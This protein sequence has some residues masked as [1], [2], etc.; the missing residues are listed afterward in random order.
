M[1]TISHWRYCNYPWSAWLAAVTSYLLVSVS[2]GVR[3]VT[4]IVS[5]YICNIQ[6]NGAIVPPS[7]SS[8][9]QVSATSN[10]TEDDSTHIQ[11]YL[12]I[13]WVCVSASHYTHAYSSW[14]LSY[15][16]YSA[17]NRTHFAA[18]HILVTTSRQ[19]H[20][21][22]CCILAVHIE[23][24]LGVHIRAIR[25]RLGKCG[26]AAAWRPTQARSCTHQ[27]PDQHCSVTRYLHSTLLCT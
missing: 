13:V 22:L 26:P 20:S 16:R 2:V 21:G 15:P 11:I 7:H 18:W 10:I 23:L 27:S 6:N 9:H 25:A 8:G 1:V 4:A 3:T 12:L 19:V 17:T 14:W 24:Q 5:D